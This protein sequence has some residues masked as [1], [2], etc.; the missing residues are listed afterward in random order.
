MRNHPVV[1]I[2]SLILILIIYIILG[3]LGDIRDEIEKFWL[4][5]IPIYLYYGLLIVNTLRNNLPEKISFIWFI[6][7]GVSFRIALLPS[8][9]F[10]SDDI[11]RYLW[12]G[13]IFFPLTG[14]PIL[15][16]ARN[17]TVLAVWLPVPLT[18]ATM[19]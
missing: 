4:L 7:F 19:I 3:L 10:L 1:H 8:E 6:I 11:Y 9:P 2:F 15:N 5:I 18:V 17:R 14:I 13:K 12:D 16:S